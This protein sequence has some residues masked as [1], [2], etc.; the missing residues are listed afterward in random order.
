M[1]DF[2][3]YGQ[4]DSKSLVRKK[5][6]SAKLSSLKL[7]FSWIIMIIL[8]LFF[9]QQRLSYIRTEKAVRV[10]IEEKDQIQLSILPLRLEERF[11]TRYDKVEKIAKNELSLQIPRQVQVIPVDVSYTKVEDKTAEPPK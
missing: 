11:L 3:R 6:T 8:A 1:K 5:T 9:V 2:P 10:L 4:R 7:A